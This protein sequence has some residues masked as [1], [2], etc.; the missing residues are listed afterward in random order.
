MDP[1]MS[2]PALKYPIPAASAA[3]VPPEI[4]RASASGPTDCSSFRKSGCRS[5][6]R[7]ARRERWWRQSGPR[8]PARAAR[9]PE[10]VVGLSSHE[11]GDSPRAGVSRHPE[12]FLHVNRNAVKHAERFAAGSSVIGL[13]GLRKGLVSQLIGGSIELRVVAVEALERPSSQL[14]GG[15][16]P[17]PDSLRRPATPTTKSSSGG[18]DLDA[19]VAV[20]GASEGCAHAEP[21]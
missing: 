16:A 4:D 17:V 7:R 12:A 21:A 13:P 6:S 1:P 10:S 3:A 15:H 14:D 20:A 2:L 5:A 9:L 18:A 11:R 8:L 19:S